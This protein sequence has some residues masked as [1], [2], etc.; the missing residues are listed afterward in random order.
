M[1]VQDF[2]VIEF[3]YSN[4][5]DFVPRKW[6]LEFKPMRINTAH[7]GMPIKAQNYLLMWSLYT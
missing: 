2:A 5:I 7:L 6:I 3:R 4:K 1:G